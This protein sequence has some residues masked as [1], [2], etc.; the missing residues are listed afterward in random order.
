LPAEAREIAPGMDYSIELPGG[1]AWTLDSADEFYAA[2]RGDIAA[3]TI[4]AFHRMGPQFAVQFTREQEPGLGRVFVLLPAR[5]DIEAVFEIF[6]AAVGASHVPFRPTVFVGHG[7]SPVWRELKDHLRE[8]Q[9]FTVQDFATDPTAGYGVTEVLERLVRTSSFAVLVHTAE[10]E[11]PDGTSRARENVV[12]ETGLFQ[13]ALGFTKAIIV[14]EQRCAP[15][16]NVAGLQEVRFGAT[17]RESFA[18]VVDIIDR[19]FP[20]RTN[21]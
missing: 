8:R 1:E 2:S 3:A 14:R 9:H 19:E 11:Q 5:H 20:N 6:E 10:D 13:G 4:R 21:A 16:S 17:I 12:H 7:R 18:D 15:F